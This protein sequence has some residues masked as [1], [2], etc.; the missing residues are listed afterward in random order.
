[1]YKSININ[2]NNKQRKL[3]FLFFLLKRLSV[4]VADMIS[5]TGN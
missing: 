1:M 5:M 3:F 4:Y 2:S